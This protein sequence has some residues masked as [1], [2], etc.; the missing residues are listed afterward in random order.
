VQPLSM[1]WC[2]ECHR[3]PQPNLR[4][5]SEITNMGWQ[6]RPVEVAQNDPNI[7]HDVNPPQ[8]C[9]GCHR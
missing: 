6:P 3:D 7:R 2:L 9:T 1:G 5:K 8:N 4:P